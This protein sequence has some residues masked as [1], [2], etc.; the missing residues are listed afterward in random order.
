ML[1]E[2]RMN[3][4]LNDSSVKNYKDLVESVNSNFNDY[5]FSQIA[6]LQYYIQALLQK[7]NLTKFDDV[8]FAF[9]NNFFGT[10]AKILEAEEDD[11]EDEI[12]EGIL[13]VDYEILSQ[14]KLRGIWRF[15]IEKNTIVVHPCANLYADF[16]LNEIFDWEN[17]YF[18]E[19]IKMHEAQESFHSA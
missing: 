5:T 11:E 17:R 1:S 7:N 15:S 4:I 2:E 13:Y 14:V 19:T 10:N 12:S 9:F 18:E 6:D 8:F 16:W 3:E